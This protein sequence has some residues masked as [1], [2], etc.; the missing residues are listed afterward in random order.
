MQR[1]LSTLILGVTLALCSTPAAS[2]Q[3]YDFEAVPDSSD[4]YTVAWFS[5]YVPE[6]T[7]TVRGIYFFVN[8]YSND[9][10]YI[11]Y[12]EPFRALVEGC[13]FALMGGRLDAVDMG[14]GI[15]DAVLEALFSFAVQSGHE[16]VEHTTLFF[17]G[18]S[19]GGQF[20]Y[21]FTKWLPE[22]TLGFVTIKG[23]YHNTDPA[24]D[25]IYVP[26]YMFIGENDLPY[27]IENLT[28]IFEEHR[29]LGARWILAME[30][31][32]GHERVTDREILDDYFLTVIE[33]RLPATIPEGEPPALRVI[34]EPSSWLGN[35][36]G[37]EIG[38]FACYDADPGEA[39]WFASRD[40]GS[41]W[42][43][44]VSDGTVT[45]TVAC[46]PATAQDARPPADHLT[47]SGAPSLFH[48]QTTFRY[49]LDHPGW[50]DLAIYTAGGE[51][52]RTLIGGYQEAGPQAV[53]WDGRDARGRSVAGGIFFG[54]LAHAGRSTARRVIRLR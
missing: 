51:C 16:E 7:P 19:W 24:G 6:T 28:G 34:P 21:H 2:A 40:V 15:G 20:S 38:Y 48:G 8:P 26:G 14:S 31:S 46:D 41:A 39:C 10:R 45:D 25:A 9:S 4:T 36:E 17:D 33:R 44:F 3:V 50:V 52:I 30:P 37:Y 11:V 1:L 5:I 12:E 54:R 49:T 22:R 53:S 32:A 29:P 42:Q 23:G 13:D 27:R 43:D 35:R 47:L 18:W